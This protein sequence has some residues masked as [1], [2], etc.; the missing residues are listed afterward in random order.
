MELWELNSCVKAYNRRRRDEARDNFTVSWQ[1]A[2]LCGAA[3]A[4]K[5]KKLN[6]YLDKTGTEKSS[7]PKISKAEFEEKLKAA[8]EAGKC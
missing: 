6:Y 3:F 1:T 4:G 5:L 7:A 8:K 2:A